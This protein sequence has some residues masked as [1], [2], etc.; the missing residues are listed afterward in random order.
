[1]TL[2]FT[3]LFSI[4]LPSMINKPLFTPY[5]PESPNLQ[6]VDGGNF[7]SKDKE[8]PHPLRRG[9]T[10]FTINFYLNFNSYYAPPK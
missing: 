2:T 3:F 6:V 5:H 8:K 10:G 9:D 7:K 1:L 4:S